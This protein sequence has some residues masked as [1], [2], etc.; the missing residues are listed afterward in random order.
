L[1][2]LGLRNAVPSTELSVYHKA[3]DDS[4][5]ETFTR[6]RPMRFS[7]H[8]CIK[9][10]PVL[11]SRQAP[12]DNPVSAPGSSHLPE[13]EEENIRRTDDFFAAPT[14]GRDGEV[15]VVLDDGDCVDVVD[16]GEDEEEDNNGEVVA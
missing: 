13:E 9:H 16:N 3:F 15:V 7:P 10:L 14:A 11:T 6:I 2:V 1:V 5:N 12:P 8:L 4:D